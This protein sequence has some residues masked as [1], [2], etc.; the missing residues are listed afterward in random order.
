M[1][2]VR[3]ALIS[4]GVNPSLTQG[5]ASGWGGHHCGELWTARLPDKTLGRWEISA[6]TLYIRIPKERLCSV[7]RSL[8]GTQPRQA[9]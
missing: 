9:K 7:L 5:I 4:A 8:A 1:T 2:A 6:Y 3:T